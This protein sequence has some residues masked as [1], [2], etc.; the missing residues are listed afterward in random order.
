MAK[1]QRRDDTSTFYT[2]RQVRKDIMSDEQTDIQEERERNR[3]NYATLARLLAEIA[4]ERDT[5]LRLHATQ[6]N[7]TLAAQDELAKV[8]DELR[9]AREE[10]LIESNKLDVSEGNSTVLRMRVEACEV[11]NERLR[12]SLHNLN[13]GKQ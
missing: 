3:D 10:L 11:E 5:V 1:G 13:G 6:V 2:P 4:G 8:K 7:V 9:A 12:Q